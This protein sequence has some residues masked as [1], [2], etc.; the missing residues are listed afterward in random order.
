MPKK[1]TYEELEQRAKALENQVVAEKLAKEDLC[2]SEEFFRSMAES[3]HDLI[4]IADSNM[5]PLW[6]NQAWE[7]RFGPFSEYKEFPREHIHP[8]DMDKA[9]EAWN[10]VVSGKGVIKSIEYR[11]KNPSGEYSVF[12]SYVYKIPS[13]GDDRFCVIA[14]DITERKHVEEALLES[15]NRYRAFFEKGSDGVV[16]LEDNISPDSLQSGIG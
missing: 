13:T 8:D 6:V 11:Y 12:D 16:I 3:S 1:P 9:V 15:E 5:K 4:T 7:D 14:H 10:R 2:Q